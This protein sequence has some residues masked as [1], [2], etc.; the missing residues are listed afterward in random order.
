[1]VTLTKPKANHP[2]SDQILGLIQNF[3]QDA[4]QR[5]I[6]QLVSTGNHQADSLASEQR[7]A[8]AL[9]GFAWGHP[10]FTEGGLLFELPSK[11]YWYDFLVRSAV[12]A[13]WLPVNIKV[14]SF[15]GQDDLS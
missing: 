10:L 8:N 14:S 3:V 1:M 15:R 5:N 6:I 13:I 4:L 12:D 2:S 7:I 11:G 9:R